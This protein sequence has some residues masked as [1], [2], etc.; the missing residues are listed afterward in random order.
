MVKMY[1]NMFRILI[2]VLVL[3]MGVAAVASLDTSN[4]AYVKDRWSKSGW[5]GYYY[6]QI[7]GYTAVYSKNS[8][9]MAAKGYYLYGG[10]YL[11]SGYYNIYLTKINYRTIKVYQKA[12]DIKGKYYY[13]TNYVRYYKSLGTYYYYKRGTFRGWQRSWLTP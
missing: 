6:Y 7:S 13:K 12:R 3:S 10:S 11:G 4:A 5:S 9:K 1:K 8:Y 2:C